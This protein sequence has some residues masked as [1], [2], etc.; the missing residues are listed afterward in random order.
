MLGSRDAR[1]RQYLV[2]EVIDRILHE[3]ASDA[4]DHG[5]AIWLL[6]TLEV[7]L[8]REGW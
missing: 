6:L 5:Q 7:F 3:H 1:I 8:R 2:P 4:R